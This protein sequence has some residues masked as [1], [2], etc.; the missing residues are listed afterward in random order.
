MSRKFLLSLSL[1][2]GCGAYE[3]I[4]DVFTVHMKMPVTQVN[5]QVDGTT[6]TVCDGSAHDSLIIWWPVEPADMKH[7]WSQCDNGT[8]YHPEWFEG[9]CKPKQLCAKVNAGMELRMGYCL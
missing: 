4:S 2:T 1:I 7:G 5:C 8:A 6:Y 3:D 9:P